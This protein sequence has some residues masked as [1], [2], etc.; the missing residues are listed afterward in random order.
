MN[1]SK[2]MFMIMI[3]LTTLMTISSTNWI[4][5]WIGMEMNLM[6]F[7]PFINKNK[8]LKSSRAMMMYFLAQSIGSIIFLFAILMNSF[9]MTP[10][11]MNEFIK[12]AMVIGMAIKL[13]MAP[14][15]SW[16]PEMMSNINWNEMMVLMTWQKVAPLY[17]LSNLM[18]NWS[19][20]ILIILSTIVGAIGG[21]N[22]TSMRKIMAYSSINHMGWITAMM[23]TQTKW[24]M[25][26]LIY[27]ITVA[28][29]CY[30]MN[31]HNTYF[32]NQVSTMNESM[33][34]KLTYSIL[35]L[36]IGGMPPFLGFLPK[37]M[38]I[39]SMINTEMMI[40]MTIMIMMSLL[41]LFYYMRM[42]SSLMLMYS[43][44]NKWMKYKSPNTMMVSLMLTINMSMPIYSIM[45]FF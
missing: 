44:M 11:M 1:Y 23:I 39:Q 35:M 29:L 27:S 19:M 41:T 40:L 38:A 9:I 16:M 12:T 4:G 18:N 33:T 37:W 2:I 30:M 7:I 32:I 42:I 20:Y 10:I 6:S 3:M 43:S 15:H 28:M 26:L 21:L 14:F 34:E 24:F 13:G 36:S 17:T 45:S 25:Y 8:N 22:Q 5:M 31:M